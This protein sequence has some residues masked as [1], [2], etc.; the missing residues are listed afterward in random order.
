MGVFGIRGG[1][2]MPKNFI[3]GLSAY[4]MILCFSSPKMSPKSWGC[5]LL[6]Q[7]GI[8]AAHCL[9]RLLSRGFS[10]SGSI[11]IKAKRD[12]ASVI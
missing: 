3:L 1:D 7:V 5:N 2:V 9:I 11:K 12:I 6:L 10:L 4:L 8:E